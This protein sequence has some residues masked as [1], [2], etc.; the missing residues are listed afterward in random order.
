MH[1]LAKGPVGQWTPS[2]VLGAHLSTA[3]EAIIRLH[4]LCLK[5]SQS[6]PPRPAHHH[7]SA[8]YIACCLLLAA[9]AKQGA[10]MKH[11]PAYNTTVSLA[12]NTSP[13]R[14]TSPYLAIA[15]DSRLVRV[16]H[17]SLLDQARSGP[18][19]AL[20]LPIAPM[21]TLVGIHQVMTTPQHTGHNGRRRELKHSDTVRI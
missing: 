20:C 10:I 6:L 5:R 1:P 19:V 4:S 7:L 11:T 16:L 12:R 14:V 17:I 18:V 13:S 21:A 15:L 2:C 8:A 9:A 3:T